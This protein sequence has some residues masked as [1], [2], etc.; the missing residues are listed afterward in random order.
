M[1][2]PAASIRRSSLSVSNGIARDWGFATAVSCMMLLRDGG[3][4][5][6][7]CARSV[8]QAVSRCEKSHNAFCGEAQGP[9]L[10]KSRKQPHAKNGS[11]PI[12]RIRIRYIMEYLYLQ[13]D[14]IFSPNS[15]QAKSV[16]PPSGTLWAVD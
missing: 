14:Q 3:S 7:E 5:Q 12:S 9:G 4:N 15:C 6:P 10:L 16:W 11:Q 1:S 2:M 13:L 8:P